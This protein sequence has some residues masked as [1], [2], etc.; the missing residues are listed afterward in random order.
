[1]FTPISI[2]TDCRRADKLPRRLSKLGKRLTEQPCA[3]YAAGPNPLFLPGIPS[4]CRD[5][6]PGEMDDR[7]QGLQSTGVDSPSVWI[8]GN[9]LAS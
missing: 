9:I 6:L 7:V 2:E 5:V 8:P 3:L 1:L 4:P